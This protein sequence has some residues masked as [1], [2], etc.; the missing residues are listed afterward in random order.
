MA[1][2]PPP[3]F[4]IILKIGTDFPFCFVINNTPYRICRSKM[5]FFKIAHYR[6]SLIGIIFFLYL[7]F[8]YSYFFFQYYM[9]MYL[10]LLSEMRSIIIYWFCLD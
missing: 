7:F 5:G 8:K 10:K 6:A 9:Y 4:N 2:I 1:W 3:L